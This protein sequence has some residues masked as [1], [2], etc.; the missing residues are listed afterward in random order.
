MTSA[1]EPHRLA[2]ATLPAKWQL[3]PTPLQSLR[4]RLLHELRSP[5][6]RE[7]LLRGWQLLGQQVDSL[8]KDIR[9]LNCIW[10]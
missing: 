6:D 4:G 9:P 3:R 2:C 7:V 5:A 10:L 8:T 1:Q